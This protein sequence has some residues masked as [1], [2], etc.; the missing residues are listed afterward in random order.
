M[1]CEPLSQHHARV[2]SR[3]RLTSVHKLEDTE[4]VIPDCRLVLIR[5][6]RRNMSWLLI[7]IQTPNSSGS[8]TS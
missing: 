5:S 8:P 6:C 2:A 1:R 3:F 4:L 7:Q